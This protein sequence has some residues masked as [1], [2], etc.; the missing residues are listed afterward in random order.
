MNYFDTFYENSDGDRHLFFT[1]RDNIIGLRHPEYSI[2]NTLKYNY[3]R[4]GYLYPDTT[5]LPSGYEVSVNEKFSI[6]STGENGCSITVNLTGKFIDGRVVKDSFKC[7]AVSTDNYSKIP[8]IIITEQLVDVN[9]DGNISAVD[10]VN[11]KNYIMGT[12][13]V[14]KN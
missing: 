12:D 3:I 14:I 5:N 6:V 13:S 1:G 11:I 8:N 10:Y 4:I 9:N 2:K 7:V